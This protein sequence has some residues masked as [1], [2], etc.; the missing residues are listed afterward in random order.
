MKRFIF[1][2]HPLYNKKP[3]EQYEGQFNLA[4][5]LGIQCSVFS[6]DTLSFHPKLNAGDE[7]ISMGFR[8]IF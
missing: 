1:P 5:K 2:S 6:M 7:I 4:K 8:N 3:D